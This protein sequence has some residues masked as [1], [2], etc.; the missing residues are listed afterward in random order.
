MSY[1]SGISEHRE[2]TT[3]TGDGRKAVAEAQVLRSVTPSGL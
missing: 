2:K 3:N 1:E